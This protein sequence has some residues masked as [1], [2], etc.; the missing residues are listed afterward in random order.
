MKANQEQSVAISAVP[1]R[2][3]QAAR[4][5]G[6]VLCLFALSLLLI[7]SWIPRYRGPIDLRWDAGVYYILGTSLAES[8]GYR[9]LNEPGEIR[10]IQYP[11]GLPAIIAAEEMVLRTNQPAVV[12]MWLR[13]S[14]V[15]LSFL[16]VLFA[17]LL[18]RQFLSRRYS[19][20]LA[21]ACLL[22]YEMYF[23]STLAFAELPFA[24]SSTAFGYFYFKK[25][26]GALTRLAAPFAAVASYLLRSVGIALL[27]AW[28][29]DAVLR[30]HYR[31]AVVRAAVALVPVLLWQSY[32][33]SV[34]SSDLYKHPYYA[35]QRDPSMF[36]N[37]SYAA[38]VS[39]KSPFQ[40]E[41]GLA[42]GRDLLVRFIGN[43][44]E[45]PRTVGEAVSAKKGFGEGHVARVN[46][47]IHPLA[48]PSWSFQIVLV[49]LGLIVFAGIAWQIRRWDW[50]IPV[51]LLL[52][53][54]AICT[55]TWIDQ[56][57]RYLA[58]VEPFLLI[59]FFS[60]LLNIK[61][62]SGRWP[63][64]VRRVTSILTVS[65][66]LFIVC[67]SALS[68]IVGYR[69]FRNKAIYVDAKGVEREYTLF[70]Y[71]TEASASQA[72]MEWLVAHA[73]PN[74]IVAVSMPQWVYLK[75]GLKTVMPPLEPDWA[76][77]QRLID[78]VPASYAVLDQLLMED[79]FNR[80]FPGLVRGSPHKWRLVYLSP[81]REFD[82]YQRIGLNSTEKQV[83][84]GSTRG[85]SLR[86]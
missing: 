50:F 86:F 38:N 41:Q 81:H 71:P 85:R 73:D 40:P 7:V 26:Q 23:V 66:A 69:N 78:S 17:F 67:E 62:T 1:S 8:K 35:Y 34:E 14:W 6:D 49:Y 10:A 74:A 51:Y 24:V 28:I 83:L 45:M 4:W 25:N 11:P 60:F 47:W 55:T 16:Y 72:G 64:R 9:L 21:A 20:L 32:I 54:A 68:C 63:V 30:K 27:L 70:H 12:G 65:T 5:G 42:N 33:R 19:F 3:E 48:L 37:V 61:R 22:N 57:P 46:R 44:V 18:G 56:F 52:T 82:I 36:Y 59:V 31:Q 53:I 13:H 84:P 76:K 79:D 15:V 80:S 77:A 58:P 75:T 2:H 29:A 43:F 39:L